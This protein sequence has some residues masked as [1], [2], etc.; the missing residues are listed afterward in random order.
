MKEETSP[1]GAKTYTAASTDTDAPTA[2]V[3]GNARDGYTIKWSRLPIGFEYSATETKVNG[4]KDPIYAIKATDSAD[5]FI[6][7]ENG[8]VLTNAS[9]G[10]YIINKPDDAVTL[11]ESGG[12]GTAMFYGMGI[13]LMAM[14]GLLLFIK[15]RN[16]KN[17]SERRW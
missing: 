6:N 3:T 11:P 12:P 4:Y 17:L 9:N 14:A 7:T 1:G 10:R 16:I 2:V 8:T 5:G 15:R 13:A